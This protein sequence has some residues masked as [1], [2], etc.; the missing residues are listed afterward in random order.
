MKTY[1][2]HITNRVHSLVQ[3]PYYECKWAS[4]EKAKECFDFS[5]EDFLENRCHPDWWEID[6]DEAE[7]FEAD[8]SDY[9]DYFHLYIYEAETDEEFVEGEWKRGFLGE[10]E[11]EIE[12]ARA[13]YDEA[14]ANGEPWP[15]RAEEKVYDDLPF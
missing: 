1:I 7:D 11:D 10:D 6:I 12:A 8:I 4:K 5:K 2:V 3:I 13:K 15:P 14:I 9:R